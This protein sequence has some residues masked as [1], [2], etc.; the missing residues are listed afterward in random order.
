MQHHENDGG[1]QRDHL[2]HLENIQIQCVGPL[3]GCAGIFAFLGQK[4][5]MTAAQFQ[6]ARKTECPVRSSRVATSP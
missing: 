1:R 3:A 2:D 6:S 4:H 5:R